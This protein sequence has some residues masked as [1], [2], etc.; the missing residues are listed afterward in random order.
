MGNLPSISDLLKKNDGPKGSP[1]SRAS[2]NDVSDKF[3]K[4]MG[5]VV[6]KEKEREAMRLA[7]SL[8]MPH[9][10]L[11]KFP[12]SQEALRQVPREDAERLETVCFYYTTDE[13]RLGTVNPESDEVKE[14]LRSMGEDRGAGR[15]LC[16]FTA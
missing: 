15:S 16:D 4:K 3:T 11:D 9:I 6:V 8:N 7:A 13:F 14:L 5:E 1:V 10:D 12:I 2:G